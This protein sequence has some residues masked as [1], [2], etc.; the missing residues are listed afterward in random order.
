MY[1]LDPML[2]WKISR[3]RFQDKI[4]EAQQEK[5]ARDVAAAQKQYKTVSRL[6]TILVTVVQLILR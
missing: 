6:R 2:N 1:D 5:F 3:Q 4:R